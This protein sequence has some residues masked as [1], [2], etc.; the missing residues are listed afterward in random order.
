[1][2]AGPY[3]L[4]GCRSFF[5]AGSTENAARGPHRKLSR[6]APAVQVTVA[7]RRP[8]EA[9]RAAW[10]VRRIHSIGGC[11]R[12]SQPWRFVPGRRRRALW[13]RSFWPFIQGRERPATMETRTAGGC[14]IGLVVLLFDGAVETRERMSRK[15]GALHWTACGAPWYAISPTVHSDIALYDM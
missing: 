8:G 9:R 7:V 14:G 3:P 1:M 11:F 5:R 15:I 4:S 10:L 2:A 6:H 13:M 12:G